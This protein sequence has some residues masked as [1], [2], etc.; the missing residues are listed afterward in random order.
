MYAK[1]FKSPPHQD[2]EPENV[3]L[4]PRA[5]RHYVPLLCVMLASTIT[6]TCAVYSK[7]T[8]IEVKQARVEED[9]AFAGDQIRQLREGSA[10]ESR[11]ISDLNREVGQLVATLKN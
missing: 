8:E 10:E 9:S 6:G 3:P 5:V 1:Q 7:L 11:Q 2:A 4:T